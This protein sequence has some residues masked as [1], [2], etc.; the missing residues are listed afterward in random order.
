MVFDHMNK[1]YFYPVLVLLVLATLIAFGRTTGNDFINFDDNKYITEN[2]N[3]LLGINLQNTKWAAT[4]VVV[5]NW[6]PLTMIS[7][8]LDW[9]LFGANAAGHHLVSLLLHIGAVILL[10][11]FLYKTTN[12]L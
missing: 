3:I 10:F 8:M 5:S 4:A 2:S 11:L 6:H 12:H 1:K 7:H 9:Q